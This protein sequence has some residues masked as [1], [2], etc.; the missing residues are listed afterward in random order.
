MQIRIGER[1]AEHFKKHNQKTARRKAVDASLGV[2]IKS[3]LSKIDH[4]EKR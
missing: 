4:L 1:L 3:A 2:T